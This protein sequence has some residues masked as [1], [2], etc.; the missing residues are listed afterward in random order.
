M[1][2]GARRG[3]ARLGKSP[4]VTVWPPRPVL[5]GQGMS[6]K[7]VA[8][9]SRLGRAGPVVVWSVRAVLAGLVPS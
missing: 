5:S 1:A 6:R 3:W 7:G 4:H 2:V 9:P 8:G